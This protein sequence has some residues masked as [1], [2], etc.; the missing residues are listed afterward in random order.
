MGS[1]ASASNVSWKAASLSPGNPQMTSV[2]IPQ[3]GTC[4]ATRSTS[5]RKP[6]AV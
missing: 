1:S 2:P 4:S 5:R 6:A 3:P